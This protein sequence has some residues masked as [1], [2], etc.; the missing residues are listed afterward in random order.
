MITARNCEDPSCQALR[1]AHAVLVQACQPPTEIIE[2]GFH[3]YATPSENDPETKAKARCTSASQTLQNGFALRKRFLAQ[4]A[5]ING[6]QSAS[7]DPSSRLHAP[8]AVLVTGELRVDNATH[9]AR[10]NQA[11]GE[12]SCDVFIFTWDTPKNRGLAELVGAPGLAVKSFFFSPH[13]STVWTPGGLLESITRVTAVFQFAWLEAALN[14]ARVPWGSYHVIARLRTDSD[15]VQLKIPHALAPHMMYMETDVA[16]YADA[17]TFFWAFWDLKGALYRGAYYNGIVQGRAH[18]PRLRNVACSDVRS[19]HDRGGM[20]TRWM[21]L[22][23]PRSLAPGSTPGGTAERILAMKRR[24]TENGPALAL[25]RRAH[26]RGARDARWVSAPLAEPLTDFPQ[27][28]V[29]EAE[30]VFL[31]RVLERCC[32]GRL[33]GVV[34]LRGRHCRHAASAEEVRRGAAS[35]SICGPR[36]VLISPAA[37]SKAAHARRT[38]RARRRH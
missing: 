34:L 26:G 30:A 29:F 32:V 19:G 20:I 14:D 38:A 37:D 7:S 23:F 1:S 36:D 9:L 17:A 16:F 33:N 21:W 2:D 28:G 6:T 15:I 35:P 11:L 10:F 25:W 8:C 4:R 12:Q 18:V 22:F 3:I 5:A 31:Q 27:W 24:A 13:S